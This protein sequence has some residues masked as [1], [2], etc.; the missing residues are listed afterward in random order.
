MITYFQTSSTLVDLADFKSGDSTKVD[1]VIR[2]S[3]IF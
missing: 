1:Q 2:S 3:L